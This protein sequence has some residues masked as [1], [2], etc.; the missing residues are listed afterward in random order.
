MQTQH[1]PVMLAE[2]LK[3]LQPAS[4]GHYVDGTIGGGGHTAAILAR[5]APEGK[6][7]GID[8]DP[9]A[10]ARV[11]TLLADEV[12]QDRLL[13]SQGNYSEVSRLVAQVDFAPV[14][15]I[16]LDLGFSSDQMEDP[17]R[18]FSFSVDGPLDMRLN[19]SGR[20]LGG[21]PGECGQRTR[22]GGYFLALW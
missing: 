21:R 2:V 18:G 16:V 1:V 14:Q 9:R 11:A 3:F 8:T 4:G 10:L 6:V 13:L 5:S 7:L 22:T 17:E 20:D 19:Q 12:R 15:G